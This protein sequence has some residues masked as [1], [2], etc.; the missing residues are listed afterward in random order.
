MAAVKIL[1]FCA[2]QPYL[3]LFKGMPGVSLDLIQIQAQK[4]FLQNWNPA[5]RP[6]PDGWRLLD[7]DEAQRRLKRGEYALVMA[8]NANDYIDFLPFKVPRVFVVHTS[9]SSRVTEER[10]KVDLDIYKQD[11]QSLVRK[12]D[13]TLVFVSEHK[14]Q[15][16]QLPGE[17]IPLAADPDDYTGFTGEEPRL[18]R[19]ANQL[20]RRGEILNYAFHKALCRGFPLTLVGH[21]PGMPGAEPAS[22]WSHLKALY[23][24]HRL[25]VHTAKPFLE[26]GYNTAMLEAM[27]T[28]MPVVGSPHPTSPIVDGENGFVSDDLDY[29]RE[30][31][32][33]LTTDPALARKMGSKARDTVLT[34][35]HIDQ[36]H[37]RWRVLLETIPGVRFV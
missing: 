25:Y 24:R 26:D 33:R 29:L 1:T 31:V 10:V 5:V 30:C 16:W 28:G 8:H 15:D 23:R 2:H 12:T 20:R 7:W 35:F 14:R 9:L 32:T 6:L 21:N 13:G 37:R 19:V 11:L 22:D 18:L 4:K 17:V 36:F 3:Y 34:S 27:A